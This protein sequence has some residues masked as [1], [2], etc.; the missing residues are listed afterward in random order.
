MTSCRAAEQARTTYAHAAAGYDPAFEHALLGA[1]TAA[2]AEASRAADC[3]VLILRTSETAS[4][5][6]TALAA[7]LA[8]SP[9]AVRSPTAI[10]KT[11]DDLHRRLRR[12]VRTAERDA[13]VQ[14]FIDRSF[15]GTETA[16]RA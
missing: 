5:L 15:H 16:G 13:V 6:L 2:I 10:R 1:I 11:A 12:H 3:N 14:D 8:M 4:A 9:D 7:V